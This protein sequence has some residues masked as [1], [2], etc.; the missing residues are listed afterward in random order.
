MVYNIDFQAIQ[1]HV[2]TSYYRETAV[3]C[4]Q[5]K[6]NECQFFYGDKKG[7]VFLVNLNN[8]LVNLF[9]NGLDFIEFGKKSFLKTFIF[10]FRDEI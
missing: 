9:G 2:V 7:N 4:L 3:T 1:P 5:W 10:N 8:F 6:K